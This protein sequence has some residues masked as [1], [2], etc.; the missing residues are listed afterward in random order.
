MSFRDALCSLEKAGYSVT[1]N[2]TGRVKKQ[3]L[4]DDKK[5]LLTL[6]NI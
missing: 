6:S 4:I 3:Q 1:F 5:V 2:G